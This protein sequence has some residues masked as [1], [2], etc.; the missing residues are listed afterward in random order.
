MEL[1]EILE[2]LSVFGEDQPLPREALAE[3]VRQRETITPVLLDA[4]DTVYERG[5]DGGGW[6]L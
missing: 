3:A 5:A 4:L 6:S 1:K 2:K